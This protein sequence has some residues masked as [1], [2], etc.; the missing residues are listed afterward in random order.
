MCHGIKP[1]MLSK[2]CQST[3]GV[4]KINASENGQRSDLILSLKIA[5]N[6]Q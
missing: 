4:L 3:N 2:A 1:K 6:Y 5:S